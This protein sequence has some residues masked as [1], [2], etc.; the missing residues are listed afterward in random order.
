MHGSWR[1]SCACHVL[2]PCCACRFGQLQAVDTAGVPPAIH[3]FSEG[4][5]LRPDAVEQ[6]PARAQL[7][8][9][10]PSTEGT[11]VRVPKTAGGGDGGEPAQPASANPAAAAP[12]VAAAPAAQAPAAVAEAV[13]ASGTPAP[14]GGPAPAVPR[15]VLHALDI[16]VGR[17]ISCERHPDADRWAMG[18]PSRP[19]APFGPPASLTTRRLSVRAACTSR[20]STWGNPS[21][22]PLFPAW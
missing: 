19:V 21:R 20:R 4:N 14:A 3:A 5:R 9:Q 22:A 15:D 7:L 11:Y 16:R 8:A 2:R 10:T 13:S 12:A 18:L 1:G 6:Y 17:I